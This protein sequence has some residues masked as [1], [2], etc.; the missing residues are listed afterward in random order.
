MIYFMIHIKKKGFFGRQSRQI[1]EFEAILVYSQNV[2]K[3]P[4][5][6]KPRGRKEGRWE[7]KVA[8][9]SRV[10]YWCAQCILGIIIYSTLRI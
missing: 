9:L 2:S 3:K 1:S 4:C 7:G 8:L 5:L 10:R 6:V